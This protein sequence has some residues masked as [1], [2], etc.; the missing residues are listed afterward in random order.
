MFLSGFLKRIREKNQRKDLLKDL[1]RNLK[2]DETQ[3]FLYLE[4]LELLDEDGLGV[5]YERLCTFVDGT[6]KSAILIETGKRSEYVRDL[7]RKEDDERRREV[8]KVSF[9]FDNV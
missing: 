3:R 9:L 4:S 2:I 1:I 6:E 7:R 8:G 5:F